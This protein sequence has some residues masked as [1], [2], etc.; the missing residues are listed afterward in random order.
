MVDQLKLALSED[1]FV[2]ARAALTTEL[3]RE[4]VRRHGPGR[5]GAMAL[6]RALTVAALFPLEEGKTE[7]VSLQFSGGGPLGTVYSELRVPGQVRGYLT[8]PDVPAPGTLSLEHKGA[9]L[10]LM[11]GGALHV[12]KQQ[13]SG[14]YTVG[15]VAL[16]NGEVDEDVEVF[17]AQSEQVPTRVRAEV[18]FDDEGRVERAWGVLAQRMPDSPPE[19]LERFTFPEASAEVGL[20]DLLSGA[21]GG[22]AYRDLEDVVLRFECSCSAERVRG[23]LKLLDPI[24]LREML[25]QD[26]GAH[27]TCRFCNDEYNVS[28]DELRTL[29]LEREMELGEKPSGQA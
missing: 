10:G 17:F 1:G 28:E 16:H 11:P 9:G 3:V 18:I 21:F 5:L 8:H 6:G 4:G 15:Q 27:V 25:D 23:G 7:S 29:L 2:R 19:A 13:P 24:E 20:E 22:D 12:V 26:K 14:G